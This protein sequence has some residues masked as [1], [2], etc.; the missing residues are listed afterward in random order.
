MDRAGARAVGICLHN[1]RT[2]ATF[3]PEGPSVEGSEGGLC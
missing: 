2:T 3:T 1:K